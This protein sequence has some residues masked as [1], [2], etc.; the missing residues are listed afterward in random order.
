MSTPFTYDASSLNKKS[1]TEATSSHVP[2]RRR[3]GVVR[4][5]SS[6]SSGV[7]GKCGGPTLA[8]SSQRR[9]HM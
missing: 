6:T 9:V 2:T 5:F 1:T 4:Y 7:E 8:F 3:S